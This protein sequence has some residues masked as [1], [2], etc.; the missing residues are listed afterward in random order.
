MILLAFMFLIP[1]LIKG[2]FTR[3]E[4]KLS[5]QISVDEDTKKKN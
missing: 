5:K 3:R 2:I 4:R 1:P